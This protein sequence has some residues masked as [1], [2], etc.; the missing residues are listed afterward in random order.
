MWSFLEVVYI[1]AEITSHILT[2]KT[3]VKVKKRG[4]ITIFR[5]CAS[6]TAL[7]FPCVEQSNS[8]VTS[9]AIKTTV[10]TATAAIVCC[11]ITTVVVTVVIIGANYLYY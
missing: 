1:P 2:A 7:V 5:R 6:E 9:E 4:R 11:N 3:T 10:S 8:L